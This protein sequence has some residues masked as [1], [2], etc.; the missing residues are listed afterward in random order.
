MLS[1]TIIFSFLIAFA[2]AFATTPFVKEL[3]KKVGAV[4]NPGE[5]RR[6]HK[7]PIPLL[8]GL[9]IFYGF[10]VSLLCLCDIDMS[11]RGMILGSLVIVITGIFDDIYSLHPLVKLA[12]QVVAAIIIVLHGIIIYR[13]SMPTVIAPSGVV[14]LGYLAVPITVIWIVAVTNAVNL[15]D[16]L[17]GLAAG[18]SS[19]A[20]MTLFC[21]ALIASENN[22]ALITAALAGACFGFLPYNFN[23]AKIFM[24]DTGAMFLGFILS[25]VSIMGVFKA[26]AVISFIVPFLVLGLPLF[27]TGFAIFRRMKNHKPIMG[28]DRGH[29]HHKLLDMGFTQRQTVGILYL[30]CTVLGLSAVVLIGAGA[31][32]ALVLVLII[33]VAMIIAFIIIRKNDDKKSEEIKDEVD[34]NEQN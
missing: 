28:A 26:Y 12:G 19:I 18:V 25:T 8:G 3:A 30:I 6:V 20:S 23:P 34:E 4:D 16:G 2:V 32:R 7:T 17:D 29:L 14:E 9:A 11:V 33:I 22:I 21:I 24:G 27:D 5:A 1:F 15:I 10:V 31:I 13:I